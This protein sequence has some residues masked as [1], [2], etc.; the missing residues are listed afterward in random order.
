MAAPSCGGVPPETFGSL[1][2]RSMAWDSKFAV[3]APSL[4]RTGATIP[5]AS[6]TSATSRWTG[7]TSGL[8]WCG[9]RSLGCCKASCDLT[10]NLS[11]R[12]AMMCLLRVQYRFKNLRINRKGREGRKGKT[13]EEKSRNMATRNVLIIP[14]IPFLF[15]LFLIRVHSRYSRPIAFAFAKTKRET[16]FISRSLR[17]PPGFL[18][19][20]GLGAADLDLLRLGLGPLGER[21]LQDALFILRVHMLRVNRIG[22]AEGPQE[23]AVAA[24]DAM[25][26]LF[27]LFLLELA[28]AL[29]GQGVVLQLD[30]QAFLID[31]RH[32]AFQCM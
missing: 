11:H 25:E 2:M 26:V 3:L 24:L 28:L 14:F 16:A 27:F 13:R 30:I 15:P 1:L 32:I 7:W 10:V 6:R 5:S 19:N 8:P 9:A 22:H 21:E 18:S 4:A 17:C 23:A 31:A 20:Q 29:H 12:I